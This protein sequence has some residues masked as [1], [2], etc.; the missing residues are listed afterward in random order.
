MN[1]IYEKA[2]NRRMI[3]RIK[4]LTPESTPLWGKMSVDQMCR[5][6]TLSIKIPQGKLDLKY[7]H[8]LSIIGRVFKQKIITDHVLEQNIPTVKELLV[9][10]HYP[11]EKSKNDLIKNFS[12]FSIEGK[13]S[14]KNLNHPYFGEM[15]YKDWDIVI[16]KHLDHHLKQFGV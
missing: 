2:A 13:A 8:L 1:S 6:C 14:I 5:H 10:R 15:T 4:K 16:W 12:R 11:F 7:N 3:E 9:R